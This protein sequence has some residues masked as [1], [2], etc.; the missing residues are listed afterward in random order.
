MKKIKLLLLTLIVFILTF[1]ITLTACG[2]GGNPFTNPGDNLGGGGT[3]EIADEV[4]DSTNDSA[5]DD[6]SD[7]SD[8]SDLSHN[9]SSDSADEKEATSEIVEISESGDYYFKGKYGGI[10]ITGEK[11]KLHFIFDGVEVATENGV[12]IDGTSDAKK[13]ELILTLKEGTVNTVSNSGLDKK[14]KEVNA[15]HIK[16]S[17]A[18][19]GTG[20]LD[21]TSNSKSA[22][23]ATKEIQIVDATLN[24]SAVNHAVTGLSVNASNCTIDVKSAGKDGINA[25]CDDETTEFTTEEGYV[26][27]SNVNYICAVEGDGIQADT[28][29]YIDGGNYDIKTAGNFVQKTQANMTAYDM[30]SDDFKYVKQSGK[31]IRIASD[32]T[33]RYSSSQ[34]Y[35]LSQGCKGIKVG[36]IEYPDP[37]NTDVE[38]T[39]TNGDYLIVILGGTF[40]IDSTDDA[41]HANSGNVL[42]EGG[43]YTLS[44]Y[45][46]A[47]TSD[48]LTKITGGD[49]NI[50]TSYEGI[51]GGYVEISGGTVSIV[52]SDDGI[53]AASDDTSVV[54]HI[55]ISGGDV[56]VNASG[57]GIDSNGSI[58]ISGG[59][60]LVYGPTTGRDAGLDADRGIVITGGKLFATSTLGMVETPSSNSTQYIVSY[61]Y[62][63]TITAGSVVSLLDSDGNTLL[64]VEILK[65]C[66]SIILSTPD[67]QNGSSYSLYGG[68]TKL[69]TFTVSSVITTIGSSGSFFPGGG[70]GPGGN[71]PGGMGPDGRW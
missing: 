66:Q 16:G 50:T 6:M 34:L 32:E 33:N 42:I 23:K 39:V 57:D 1:A 68:S 11:L 52:S 38:I 58:L 24:L 36:E 62:Q 45:D 60:V 40:N 8:L 18:I 54:E 2:G 25:E 10:H 13:T 49:I 4:N 69:T 21:I 28:V 17:L 3:G 30:K 22:L 15:I 20:T 37:A 31:Y 41:I 61:A 5:K 55:I 64:S 48:N 43:T 47:I 7:K 63:S 27:L 70:M 9:T 29:I 59:T 14:G 12:A 53:N 51:E 67:L 65:N 26:S 44:T 46:D 71:R 56:K 35:G 19:N